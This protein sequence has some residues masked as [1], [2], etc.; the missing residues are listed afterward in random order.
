MGIVRRCGRPPRP[1][2]LIHK[3]TRPRRDSRELDAAATARML[4]AT[5]VAMHERLDRRAPPRIPAA[6][7][8]PVEAAPRQADAAPR[9]PEAA[10]RQPDDIGDSHVLC[11]CRRHQRE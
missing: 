6:W 4:A 5:A 2:P 10:P 11:G 9:Q 8:E 7:C 1:A 3:P